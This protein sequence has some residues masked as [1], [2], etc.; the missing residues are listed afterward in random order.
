MLDMDRDLKMLDHRL[1]LLELKIKNKFFSKKNIK[2]DV[3]EEQEKDIY[4]GVLLPE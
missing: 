4:S 3:E 2:E 1:D